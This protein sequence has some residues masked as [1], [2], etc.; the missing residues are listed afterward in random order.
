MNRWGTQTGAIL[1]S[2]IMLV[3]IV[4]ILVLSLMQ[5]VWLYFKASNQIAVK[6]QEFYQ[7]EA[8]AFRPDLI[9]KLL[10]NRRCVAHE[11]DPNQLVDLLLTH[12]GCEYEIDGRNYSYLLS[13]SGVFPCLKIV[14]GNKNYA[15]H[16]WFVTIATVERTI[17]Q[18][19]I[20][21]PASPGV[22]EQQVQCIDAGVIS[23][24]YLPSQ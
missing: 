12:Q 9:K 23:W 17:L 18:L 13:D 20:A 8:I 16:H 1:L 15:S 14:S 24:R 3:V 2:T 7:L 5:A 21:L 6:H 4:T 19:R 10:K 22:C 11:A